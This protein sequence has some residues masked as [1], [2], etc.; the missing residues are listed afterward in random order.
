[1]EKLFGAPK[2]EYRAISWYILFYKAEFL[3]KYSE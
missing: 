2:L 3:D 1:M